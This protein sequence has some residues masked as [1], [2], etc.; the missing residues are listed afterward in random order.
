[1]ETIGTILATILLTAYNLDEKRIHCNLEYKFG[2]RHSKQ[3]IWI[4]SPDK[5]SMYNIIECSN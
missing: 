3:K 2:K 5:K 1:M 4:G